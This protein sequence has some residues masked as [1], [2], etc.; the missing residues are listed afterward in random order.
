MNA[1][2]L[3]FRTRAGIYAHEARGTAIA[4][5]CTLQSVPVALGA[6]HHFQQRGIQCLSRSSS[7]EDQVGTMAAVAGWVVLNRAQ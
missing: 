4:T 3:M 6:G 1:V 7:A 5:N 2:A